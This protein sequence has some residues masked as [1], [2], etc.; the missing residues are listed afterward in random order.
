MDGALNLKPAACEHEHYFKSRACGYCKS[1]T[2]NHAPLQRGKTM[3]AAIT[4]STKFHGHS[5][6]V[7]RRTMH[8][9]S[10]VKKS[11]TLETILRQCM[12]AVVTVA[13]VAVLIQTST[14]FYDSGMVSAYLEASP[15][16]TVMPA[17]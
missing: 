1:K 3:G 15:Y 16:I 12:T 17:D 11:G 6:P 8:V 4:C 5:F 9:L 2:I 10:A 7:Y 14:P 13:V